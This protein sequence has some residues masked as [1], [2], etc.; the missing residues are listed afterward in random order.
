MQ[1]NTRGDSGWV[2]EGFNNIQVGHITAYVVH[3]DCCVCGFCLSEGNSGIGIHQRGG[4]LGK[5]K[6][7][8]LDTF[9]VGV[10]EYI[11]LYRNLNGNR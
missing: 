8:S 9:A 2:E 4:L 6:I 3:S 11:Y 10:E 1:D 5:Q 7:C